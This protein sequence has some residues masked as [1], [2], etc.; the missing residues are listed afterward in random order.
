MQKV[1]KYSTD[2]ITNAIQN[3]DEK[4]NV[5]YFYGSLAFLSDGWNGQD[6]YISKDV[7]VKYVDSVCGKFVVAKYNEWKQDVESHESDLNII[8]YIP[9]D[10]K[11]KFEQLEDGR[12]MAIVDCLLSKVYCSKVYDMFTKD[13]YRSVSVEMSVD[14]ADEEQ[15]EISKFDIH[16]VTILGKDI[17]PAIKDAN[18]Q[19]VKFSKEQLIEAYENIKNGGKQTKMSKLKDEKDKVEKTEVKDVKE[20]I[21]EPKKDSKDKEVKES[22]DVKEEP[23]DKDEKEQSKE[24]KKLSDDETEMSD[25]TDKAKLSDE[26]EMSDE[27]EMGEKCLKDF[28]K[29]FNAEEFDDEE[30]A[31]LE[32]N[33]LTAIMSKVKDM[34]TKLYKFEEE[35]LK[36]KDLKAKEDFC[37]YAEEELKGKVKPETFE[38][39]MKGSEELTAKDFDEYLKNCKLKAFEEMSK[40]LEEDEKEEKVDSEKLNKGT[41]RFSWDNNSNREDKTS[42]DIW[43]RL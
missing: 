34:K 38:E 12:T 21:E 37:K 6:L 2:N 39:F 27:T 3:T 42:L 26:A 32:A 14:F 35:E 43:S 33:D 23:K 7:L 30:L 22:K 41:L 19:I 36:A 13:N 20:K 11:V 1:I 15:E 8:G 40:S 17:A 29:D 5:D 28:I 24:T 4:G 16:G 9:P 31:M 18:L 10:A 25:K